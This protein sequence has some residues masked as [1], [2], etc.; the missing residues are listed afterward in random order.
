MKETSR[1]TRSETGPEKDIIERIG[2]GVA[3]ADAAETFA[4]GQRIGAN[5]PPGTVLGLHGDLGAG[6]TT[7]AQGI[8]AGWGVPANVKSPTFNYFFLYRGTR[9][10]LVHLD[11]YRIDGPAGY[12]SLLIE[13]LLE[14]P[15]L[16]VAEWAGRVVDRLPAETVHLTLSQEPDTR[17]RC[18]TVG[19]PSTPAAHTDHPA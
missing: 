19:L 7:L 18:L 9:G 14:D 16:L 13:D 3:L 8:A 6:K 5:I 17:G 11:A 10:L 1:E 15:W 12:D 4:W 2:G